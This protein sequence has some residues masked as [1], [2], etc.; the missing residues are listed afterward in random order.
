MF[1]A[2]IMK[3]DLDEYLTIN[4]IKCLKVAASTVFIIFLNTS[5]RK[6]NK[7]ALIATDA[8]S[9]VSMKFL[10]ISF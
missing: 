5:A 6:I 2:K 7:A 4:V 10:V 8:K 3:G 1:S 9:K